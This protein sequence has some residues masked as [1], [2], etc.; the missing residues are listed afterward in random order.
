VSGSTATASDPEPA[1]LSAALVSPIDATG[2]P[3]SSDAAAALDA[4]AP[5][6]DLL[7]TAA[8]ALQA[9]TTAFDDLANSISD[10]AAEATRAALI[11]GAKALVAAVKATSREW[12]ELQELV[13]TAALVVSLADTASDTMN[14]DP[15][16][17]LLG[18]FTGLATTLWAQLQVAWAITKQIA[19]VSLKV[20]QCVESDVVDF[21]DIDPA[22]TFANPH[23][24][25]AAKL[26]FGLQS[27]ALTQPDQLLSIIWAIAP[28]AVHLMMT[29]LRNAYDDLYVQGLLMALSMPDVVRDPNRLGNMIGSSAGQLVVYSLTDLAFESAPVVLEFLGESTTLTATTATTARAEIDMGWLTRID[30]LAPAPPDATLSLAADTAGDT[31]SGSVTSGGT[32]ASSGSAPSASATPLSAPS[33]DVTSP[34]AAALVTVTPAAPGLL[35]PGVSAQ[36]AADRALSINI[37]A[38]AI[39]RS[40]GAT[41]TLTGITPQL[42]S[43]IAKQL[44][45][46]F[47]TTR[48]A[49]LLPALDELATDQVDGL[50]WTIAA[51]R[52]VQAAC[53]PVNRAVSSVVLLEILNSGADYSDEAVLVGEIRAGWLRVLESAHIIDKRILPYLPA[54]AKSALGW[55]VAGD[56]DAMAVPKA[57]HTGSLDSLFNKIFGADIP[58]LSSAEYDNI[59]RSVRNSILTQGEIDKGRSLPPG[60]LLVTKATDPVVVL[61]KFQQVYRALAASN[62]A[63]ATFAQLAC[64]R[65]DALIAKLQGP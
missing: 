39:R 49:G 53:A 22:T 10:A 64:D 46:S 50:K 8:T 2:A 16:E 56:M 52:D 65:I 24:D 41:G 15:L 38:R 33:S 3:G 17:F 34:D 43:N 18:F 19:L 29:V 1:L 48:L 30:D 40:R 31:T 32:A 54:S 51:H 44:T 37:V 6:S 45:A 11:S 55:Q 47:D 14:N 23:C 60:A 25:N 20:Y 42:V 9:I 13:T 12:D 35:A 57:D 63:Y 26:A 7:D 62:S 36:L 58:E 28:D 5:P 61:R 21:G 4:S 59:T 27:A